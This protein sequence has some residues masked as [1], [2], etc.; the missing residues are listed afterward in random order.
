MHV[1]PDT[2]A[3]VRKGESVSRYRSHFCPAIDT[4]KRK[5]LLQH[6][7]IGAKLLQP[8]QA[9]LGTASRLQNILWKNSAVKLT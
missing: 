2:L 3:G 1:T 9:L 8:Q 6:Y 7:R 4:R 5:Q